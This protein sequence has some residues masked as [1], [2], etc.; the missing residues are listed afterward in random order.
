MKP[1]LYAIRFLGTAGLYGSFLTRA[2]AMAWA[3]LECD[4]RA[5]TIHQLD[6]TT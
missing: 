4:G 3:R 6:P 5:F 2:K 1:T